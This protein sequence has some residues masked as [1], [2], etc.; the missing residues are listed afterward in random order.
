MLES[1]VRYNKY[2]QDHLR[3]VSPKLAAFRAWIFTQGLWTALWDFAIMGPLTLIPGVKKITRNVPGLR[4]VGGSTSDLISLMLLVP[5]LAVALTYGDGDDEVE[6]IINY[7]S[8]R[9]I[10]GFGGRW[11]IDAF[12]TMLA[13]I[14]GEDEDELIDRTNKVL[15]PWLPPPIREAK[16]AEPLIKEILD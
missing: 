16:L 13:F 3:T 6:R 7:Y 15:S 5:G 1:L 12:L 9:T 10:L 14:E 4:T 8:R 11:T 2:S